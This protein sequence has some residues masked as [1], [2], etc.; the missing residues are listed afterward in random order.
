M[1][2]QENANLVEL[3][4]ALGYEESLGDFILAIEGRITIEEA[5]KKLKENQKKDK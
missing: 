2:M 1:T 5:A 3:L 4:R